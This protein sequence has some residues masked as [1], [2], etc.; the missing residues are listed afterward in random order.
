MFSTSDFFSEFCGQ[1]SDVMTPI[2]DY[3][4]DYFHKNDNK[5]PR[6]RPYKHAQGKEID[7]KS[8]SSQTF[9]K[10]PASLSLESVYE[11]VLKKIYS[12]IDT[13]Q[14]SNVLKI[15]RTP[16]ELVSIEPTAVSKLFSVLRSLYESELEYA[17][18][19]DLANSVYR[20]MLRDTKSY[21][22][23]L[24]EANTNEDFLLFGNL[25][26]ISSISRLFVTGLN[27]VITAEK[28]TDVEINKDFWE[29][30]NADV[31]LQNTILSQLDIGKIFHTNFFRIK[32]TYLSYCGS[33]R[34][35]MELFENMRFK[36]PQ[37]F[38]RWYENSYKLA[39]NR[40][41]EDILSDPVRRIS[42]WLSFLKQFLSLS[43]NTLN[44]EYCKSIEEAYE[45]YYSFSKYLENETY[46][47]NKNAMYDFSL[48]PIEIIQSYKPERDEDIKHQL[49]PLAMKNATISPNRGSSQDF[50][51]KKK[52][53]EAYLRVSNGVNSVFSG[54][55]S[56]YSGD[57]V[58]VQS[59][60]PVQRQKYLSVVSQSCGEANN[61]L[62]DYSSR[63]KRIHRGLIHL[64]DILS[65]DGML[66]ILDTNLQF[67]EIWR[68]VVECHATKVTDF[69]DLDKATLVSSMCS[70]YMFQLKKQR[71]E[72]TIMKLTYFEQ[73]VKRPLML[74][75]EYC[76]LVRNQLKDLN[77]LKKDYMI[78]LR[79]RFSHS[80][81]MKRDIIGKHFERM[82]KKMAQDLPHFIDLVHQI[83]TFLLLNYHKVL[84]KYLEISA[85]GENFI[86]RDLEQLGKL[87]RDVGKNYDIVQ[88]YSTSRYCAKRLVR[89][90]W[91]FEQ[92][93]TSS[94][95]LRKLFEL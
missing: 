44:T 6:A 86:I 69:A 45:K 59:L 93:P 90:N 83:L 58:A 11:P 77:S 39:G 73:S 57:T 78:Y 79:Q 40:K 17:E 9:S 35:Q 24:L 50:L 56:R 42:Q 14:F 4:N 71:E 43:R 37:L 8:K 48:T 18:L 91:N 3:E 1:A 28:K 81:D 16:A 60:E 54:T 63:F 52:E 88:A 67:V 85:G 61:T 64:K 36:N 29:L 34:K 10:R 25:E 21:R 94:R 82:H 19:I 51:V 55:S 15:K 32:S 72:A 13:G 23:K 76:D 33:H 87:K 95:V 46:E 7:A 20:K 49:K 12:P 66:S 89:E 84:L 31:A 65:D 38:Y 92:D 80:V 68:Q 27:N 22:N 62:A 26:T 41:L 74:L 75:L 30:I 47:F 70:A 53:N 5:L 2:R